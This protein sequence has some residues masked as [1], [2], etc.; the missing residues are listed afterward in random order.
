M[1]YNRLAL[2]I[3]LPMLLICFGS[4]N[5]AY[6][7]VKPIEIETPKGLVA[8]VA[9]DNS[10][11]IV[12]FRIS[13]RKSGYA[14][15]GKAKGGLAGISASMLSEGAGEYNSVDFSKKLEELSSTISF[16]TTEDSLVLI[17]KCLTENLDATF[18]LVSKAIY[19]PRLEAEALERVKSQVKS[20]IDKQDQ[21]PK[22]IAYKQWK[23]AAFGDHPYSSIEY[24]SKTDIDNITVED[25]KEYYKNTFVR[26][27]L[28]IGVSGDI[29]P[30]KAEKILSKLFDALAEFQ[31]KPRPVINNYSISEGKIDVINNL[32]SPQTHIVFGQNGINRRDKKYIPLMIA[33]HILAGGGFTSRL[34]EQTRS[35]SGLVYGISSRLD[36]MSKS[37]LIIGSTSTANGTVGEV[38]KLIKTEWQKAKENGFTEQ[39]LIDAKAY[40][41]GSFPLSIDTNIEVA[42]YLTSMQI[43]DLG[44]DYLE[45][46]ND[47]INNVTLSELNE[48]ARKHLDPLNLVFVTAGG[49]K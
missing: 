7:Y 5:S 45:K 30:D 47:I 43:N 21:L 13:F 11:P 49:S 27:N 18:Q 23:K 28:I 37:S 22:E 9:E 44:I 29:K 15:D 17:V 25:I 20:F 26:E 42:S 1:R 19:T 3:I 39:E 31:P 33:N 16:D 46:R 36:N 35:K 40:L 4:V 38:I 41:T 12:T 8:W 2:I 48:V 14:Y 24:P 32:S 34:V 6:S 10:L